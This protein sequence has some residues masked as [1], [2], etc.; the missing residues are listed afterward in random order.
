MNIDKATGDALVAWALAPLHEAGILTHHMAPGVAKDGARVARTEAVE[1]VPGPL[2]ITLAVRLVRPGDVKRALGL[3]PAV[4]LSLGY[5]L[6][7]P[8]G[9]PFAVRLYQGTQ[10]MMI[11]VPRPDPYHPTLS[12]LETLGEDEIALGLDAQ[13]GVARLNL[14]TAAPGV[15][16]VG[17]TGS[18]KSTAMRL[19]AASALMRGWKLGAL[20]DLKND[21]D[22]GAFAPFAGTVALDPAQASAAF[23]V[24]LA[25]MRER[26]AGKRAKEP[27]VVLVDELVELDA[28]GKDKLARLASQCR[29][30]NIRLLLGTQR[31]GKELPR[32]LVSQLATRL[33]G[34]VHAAGDSYDA[35]G[36]PDAG[37]E[38]LTG[39]GD[40]LYVRGSSV[41]RVSVAYLPRADIP[42]MLG[43]VPRVG[44]N[45]PPYPT[46]VERAF[47]VFV[48]ETMEGWKANAPNAQTR[49]PERWLVHKALAYTTRT[50]RPPTHGL[51]RTWQEQRGEPVLSDARRR[52]V[53][54][55]AGAWLRKLAPVTG[56]TGVTGHH[57]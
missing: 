18:G 9:Q 19:V 32:F 15:L 31:A 45:L 30:A 43:K 4:A 2:T 48:R 56:I 12:E 35:T 55:A 57:G 53:M 16:F 20:I 42:A 34:Q 8:E 13:M 14:S 26:M 50:R 36:V 54:D 38:L 27:T 37:A 1:I 3:G 6:G 22:Y 23:D 49:I 44:R 47:D 24:L 46:P 33:V 21:D 40:M 11:E 41:A 52:D 10:R 17:M 39:A 7:V 28:G 29:S 51:I 25:E 5:G